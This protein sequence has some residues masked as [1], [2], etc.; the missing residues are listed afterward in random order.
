VEIEDPKVD[1]VRLLGLLGVYI[2][3]IESSLV[4]VVVKGIGVAICLKRRQGHPHV[5]Q[6]ASWLER[7]GGGGGGWVT[8]Y[9]P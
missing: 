4:V 6:L 8:T 7:G 2:D 5:T 3:S 9:Y 1:F